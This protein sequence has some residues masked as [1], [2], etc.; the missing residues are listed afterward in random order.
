MG[1][2]RSKIINHLHISEHKLSQCSNLSDVRNLLKENEEVNTNL[3][4]QSCG[5]TIALMS[6]VFERLPLKEKY[7]QVLLASNIITFFR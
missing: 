7:I 4:K 2:M 5:E 1:V 3:L 6:N